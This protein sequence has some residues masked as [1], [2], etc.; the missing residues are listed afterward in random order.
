MG[1]EATGI[2]YKLDANDENQSFLSHQERIMIIYEHVVHAKSIK[3]IS[4][5]MHRSYSSIR[6]IIAAYKKNGN[7]NRLR[8]FKEKEK[9]VAI[10]ARLKKQHRS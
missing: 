7:T 1:A 6:C 3:Q 4:L 9:L 2:D 10:N 5:E 8:N